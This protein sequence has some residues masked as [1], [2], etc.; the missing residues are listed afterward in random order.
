MYR[1]FIRRKSNQ[2]FLTKSFHIHS[3]NK[4]NTKCVQIGLQNLIGAS[5]YFE[6]KEGFISFGNNIYCS[7]SVSM[8]S[9]SSISIGDNVAIAADVLLYDHDSMPLDYIQRRSI[10]SHVTTTYGTS[11]FY[12]HMP[13][14][15]VKTSPIV[16]EH[17]VWIGTR[18][19]ILKGVTIGHSSVIAAGT[20]VTKSFPPFSLIGGCPARFIRSLKD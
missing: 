13:W 7:S 16:I 12:T 4:I 19:I 11:N 15:G 6:D 3:A 20:I 8:F 18:S 10:T 14:D 2:S 5:L 17:D 9:R 1:D